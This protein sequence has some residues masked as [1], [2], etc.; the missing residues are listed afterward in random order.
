MGP[1]AELAYPALASEGQ[2]YRAYPF[3]DSFNAKTGKPAPKL[4]YR[5]VNEEGLSVGLS[6]GALKQ[7]YPN[8]AG[9]CS[10][11]VNDI[12]AC[13]D[14][15]DVIQD[16]PQHAEIVGVPLRSE[17]EE[18]A[19]RIARYLARIAEDCSEEYSETT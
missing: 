4:F 8:A 15:L 16:A 11:I 12:R 1:P 2:A 5:K 9:A 10:L 3:P 18:K 6:L 13:D 14:E 7:A 19:L 17:D